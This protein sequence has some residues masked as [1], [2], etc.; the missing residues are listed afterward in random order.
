M[1]NKIDLI[2]FFQTVCKSIKIKLFIGSVFILIFIAGCTP[3]LIEVRMDEKV[4]YMGIKSLPIKAALVMPEETAYF[5]LNTKPSDGKGAVHNFPLGGTFEEISMELFS[6]IFDELQLVRSTSEIDRFE[7]AIEPNIDLFDFGYK[8]SKP[9]INE[10]W[11][12]FSSHVKLYGNADLIWDEKFTS[13]IMT[14]AYLLEGDDLGVIASEAIKSVIKE[15]CWKITSL[16]A[17]KIILTKVNKQKVK[18]KK[19]E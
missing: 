5:I 4:Q 7:I 17:T 19:F 10:F 9:Y 15:V 2:L 16:P 18:V 1:V 12:K 6:Q 8:I 3:S 11:C 13:P 14:Q